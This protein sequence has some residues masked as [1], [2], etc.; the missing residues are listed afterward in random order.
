MPIQ[1]RALSIYSS[2]Q[3]LHGSDVTTADAKTLQ[4]SHRRRRAALC[5]MLS[6]IRLVESSV[7]FDPSVMML[8]STGR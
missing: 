2:Y 6:A 4:L 7:R 8:E 3:V 5:S 1:V